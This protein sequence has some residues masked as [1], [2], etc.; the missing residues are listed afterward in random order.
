MISSVLFPLT[1]SFFLFSSQDK[2][3]IKLDDHE[4]E[5]PLAEGEEVGSLRF[6]LKIYIF[7]YFDLFSIDLRYRSVGFSVDQGS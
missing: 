4:P 1:N 2:L 3:L 6:D 5:T 7:K